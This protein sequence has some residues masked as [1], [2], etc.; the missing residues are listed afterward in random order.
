M[1]DGDSAK[2]A[3]MVTNLFMLYAGQLLRHAARSQQ[4]RVHT[5]HGE[6]AYTNAVVLQNLLVLVATAA[7]SLEMKQL[8]IQS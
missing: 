1:H 5:C 8:R 3:C 7:S 4:N 6:V 2:Q